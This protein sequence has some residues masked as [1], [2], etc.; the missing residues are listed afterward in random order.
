MQDAY[1]SAISLCST[2]KR[3]GYDAYIINAKLQQQ[4]LEQAPESET[5]EM[6]IAANASIDDMIKLFPETRTSSEPY[7]LAA[8]EKDGIVFI[9]YPSDAVEGSHPD[10]AQARITMR[11]LRK[12]E[13]RQGLEPTQ[14]C[15]YLPRSLDEH[16]GFKDIDKEGCICFQ[17]IPD[18]TLRQNYLR[19]IRAL[20]FAANYHLPIEANTWISIIRGSQPLQDYLAYTD[21]MN[22]WKK[23]EAENMHSFVR[24][25]FDTQILRGMM[26][27]IAALTRLKQ[28]RPDGEEE[29]VFDHS[30]E[31]MRLYPEELPYDWYGTFACLFKDVGKLFT[32]EFI[33]GEWTFNQS[34]FV[35]AKITRQILRRLRFTPAD[36]DL[37]CHL[38]KNYERFNYMLTDRGILHFKALDQYPRLIEIARATL[39]A[40]NGSYAAFN[41][42]MKNL[43]RIKALGEMPEPLLNGNEIMD[44]A[45][46]NPGPAV[47]LI[48][49]ALIAAQMTG[50]VQTIP[51][52]VEFIARYKDKE[53]L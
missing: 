29:V 17:G 6:E 48:R 13:N 16:E 24:M 52:A 2:L 44:F 20:R 33:N 41:S 47:G 37:I 22:E 34:H 26:P 43:E 39:K 19:G 18:E 5:V 8:L 27:E 50:E 7:A 15:S 45:G 14:I 23:V 32:A 49:E 31:T 38:V 21:I 46:I 10:T 25:L 1:K 3:N 51:D 30:L 28:N 36:A 11:M 4:I 12:L 9:F 42:N 40:N 35:G 53:S